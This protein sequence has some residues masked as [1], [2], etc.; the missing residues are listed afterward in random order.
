MKK[1]YVLRI[2]DDDD[3]FEYDTLAFDN[4]DDHDKAVKVIEEVNRYWY[5]EECDNDEEAQALGFY[6]YMVH[7]LNEQNLF[8]AITINKIYV[9]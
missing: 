8:N 7:R 9:R 3:G 2:L 4:L 5:S 6:E 1:I